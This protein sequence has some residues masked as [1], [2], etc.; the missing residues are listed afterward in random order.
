MICPAVA[1]KMQVLTDSVRVLHCPSLETFSTDHFYP[2]VPVKLT[3]TFYGNIFSL[4]IS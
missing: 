4:M 3:G 2:R 1:P